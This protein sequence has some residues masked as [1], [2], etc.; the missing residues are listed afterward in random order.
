MSTLTERNTFK[1]SCTLTAITFAE[2]SESIFHLSGLLSFKNRCEFLSCVE[3]HGWTQHCSLG[4][5]FVTLSD[6]VEFQ[7]WETE[8]YF[9]KIILFAIFQLP[10]G[11]EGGTHE[12]E[13]LGCINI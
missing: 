7:C 2:A 5:Q 13:D 6:C 10:L 1:S 9:S 4:L 3:F 12:E 11:I 8:V